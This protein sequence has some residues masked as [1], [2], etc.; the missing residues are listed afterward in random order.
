M[1]SFRVRQAGSRKLRG[2]LPGDNGLAGIT[3]LIVARKRDIGRGWKP[4]AGYSPA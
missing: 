4:H 3:I 1:P 2:S